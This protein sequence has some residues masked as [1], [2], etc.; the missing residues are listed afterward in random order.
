MPTEE[1]NAV[2]ECVGRARAERQKGSRALDI[3]LYM[4]NVLKK[5]SARA[6]QFFIS[7]RLGGFI[8]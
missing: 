4:V 1:G 6:L 5:R 2:E 7:F 8:L 3:T